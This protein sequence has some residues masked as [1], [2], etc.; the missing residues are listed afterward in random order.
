MWS[1]VRKIKAKQKRGEDR[2]GTAGKW[3]VSF[4]F[5]FYWVVCVKF[6]SSIDYLSSLILHN[7]WYFAH[8]L[9]LSLSA[10]LPL[11]RL[12]PLALAHVPSSRPPLP[13]CPPFPSLSPVFFLAQRFALLRE[14]EGTGGGGI[15]AGGGGEACFSRFNFCIKWLSAE[16]FSVFFS[17]FSGSA[18]L[19]SRRHS[20]DPAK[21]SFRQ[22][23][24]HYLGS[25][26]APRPCTPSRWCFLCTH[27][28][29]VWTV[30]GGA[31]SPPLL[32]SPLILPCTLLGFLFIF[33]FPSPP[34]L[35]FPKGTHCAGLWQA[36]AGAREAPGPGGWASAGLGCR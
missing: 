11:D 2:V 22:R 6:R 18:F 23:L 13:L 12:L 24:G 3:K 25:S 19:G 36:R 15:G 29:K 21:L 8:S 27:S 7:L 32:S 28:P 1:A 30:V 17:V 26:L 14:G 5:N 35:K 16:Q 4:F 10:S 20:G 34:F 33:L 9:S 31:R